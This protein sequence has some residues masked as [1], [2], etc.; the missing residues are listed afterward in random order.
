MTAR[1]LKFSVLNY[2]NGH[3]GL[4]YL[5][6]VTKDGRRGS[7]ASASVGATTCSA[8]PKVVRESVPYADDFGAVGASDVP[9]NVACGGS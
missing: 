1:Y 9:S 7:T 4:S 6:A 2:Y 8:A 3:G 5:H